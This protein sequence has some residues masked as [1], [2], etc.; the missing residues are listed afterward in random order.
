MTPE[1]RKALGLSR[2]SFGPLEVTAMAALGLAAILVV[3]CVVILSM[4]DDCRQRGGVLVD[5]LVWY[6]CVE[7]KR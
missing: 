1:E 4:S 5:G 2:W 6:E 7:A 3:W